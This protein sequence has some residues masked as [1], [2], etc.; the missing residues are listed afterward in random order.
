MQ[1]AD[2]EADQNI[3]YDRSLLG[4]DY[5]IGSFRITQDLILN[6]VKST[7]EA[8]HRDVKDAHQRDWEDSDFIAPPT[9][10]SVLVSGHRRPDIKLEFGDTGFFAGQSIDCLVPVRSGDVLEAKTRLKEVYPKTG[11]SG[12][13]VFIVWETRFTNQK[14]EEVALTRDSYVRRTLPVR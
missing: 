14:G 11:R 10:C 1:Q 6:F 3:K 8:G 7:G 5:T 12:V 13:M 9:F 4:V 2:I